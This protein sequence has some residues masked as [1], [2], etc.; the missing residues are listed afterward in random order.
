MGFFSSCRSTSLRQNG[1]RLWPDFCKRRRKI[2]LA[3]NELLFYIRGSKFTWDVRKA[4][5]SKFTGQNYGSVYFPRVCVRACE[6][7]CVCV[8]VSMR[9]RVCVC[10]DLVSFQLLEHFGLKEFWCLLEPN[11]VSVRVINRN[12]TYIWIHFDP[13]KRSISIYNPLKVY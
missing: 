2:W 12:R 7:V 5:K 3:D 11:S 8:C 10:V 6:C 9:M 13:Y 1:V 4:K